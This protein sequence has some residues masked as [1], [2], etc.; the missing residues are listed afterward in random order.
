LFLGGW[1][2][3]DMNKTELKENIT[4][5]EQL[6]RSDN[7]EGGFE[8]IKTINETEIT[9]GLSDVINTTLREKYFQNNALEAG[10]QIANF[11]NLTSLDLSSCDL[12]NIDALAN[13]TNL[14]ELDLSGNNFLKNVDV[15]ANLINITKLKLNYCDSLQNVDVLAN[16]INLTYLDLSQNFHIKNI[17]ALT[18]LTNLT[19]LNL[20]HCE[21]L[22]NNK[23]LKN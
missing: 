14:T 20:S 21:L 6:L 23:D 16:L 13:L 1:V 7:Y 15:L 17:D 5:I 9:E 2:D 22:Q 18:N 19:N 3:L 8:L 11:I 12:K 4:K 10:L